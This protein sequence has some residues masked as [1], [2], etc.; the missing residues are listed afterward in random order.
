VGDEI[1]LDDLRSLNSLIFLKQQKPVEHQ[2]KLSKFI[3]R[4]REKD[5]DVTAD[6]VIIKEFQEALRSVP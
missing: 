2:A 1:K 3:K 5:E 4:W 6:H